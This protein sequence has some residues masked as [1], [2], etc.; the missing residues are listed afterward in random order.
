VDRSRR[1]PGR[2]IALAGPAFVALG[3]VAA[4]PPPAPPLRAMR[5]LAPGVD[6]AAALTRRPTECLAEPKAHEAAYD[7]ELG[8]AAFRTPLLLGGQAARTGLTC[9]SCHRAGRDNP[10][11]DFP[12]VSGAPGTA[13]VTTSVLSS[14]EM[15][16]V[17]GARPIPD[18]SGPK[19]ALR[20]P[21]DPAS[22][23]LEATIDRIA[24]HEF[25]G[26]EPPPAVLKGLA[27]Y[28]RDLSPA[29]CPKAATEPVTA[30]AA[31][32]DVRR[33]VLAAIAA[34]DHHDGASAALMVEAARSQ[35]GDIDE[36]Y[37]GL[38]G[39]RRA[40]AQASLDLAAAETAARR[41]PP[42]ARADLTIWLAAEPAWTPQIFAAESQSLY[43]PVRL[44]EAARPTP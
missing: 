6:A 13:D 31:L 20:T 11:F 12:G 37:P 29:A 26:A 40:L 35:L 21:Q 23:A 32:T 42:A 34:L 22:G 25:D 7:V 33:A 3:L 17:H 18:L 19:S 1:R 27:A 2:L 15:A 30:A 9:E 38:P 43:N 5:W 44:A 36:R 24:T 41:D 4:A 14:H 28:V 10:Q 8:R 16:S 39:P